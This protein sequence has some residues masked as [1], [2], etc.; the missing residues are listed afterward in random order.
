MSNIVKG[1]GV[2]ICLFILAVFLGTPVFGASTKTAYTRDSVNFISKHRVDENIE[3]GIAKPG[4]YREVQVPLNTVVVGAFLENTSKQTESAYSSLNTS[5]QTRTEPAQPSE[6][7]QNASASTSSIGDRSNFVILFILIAVTGL[8]LFKKRR[9]NIFTQYNKKASDS[10]T[11]LNSE[12][13][14]TK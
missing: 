7:T 12:T 3:V 5:K 1:L 8:Y 4:D 10:G 6:A 2:I 14:E 11:N 9:Q 13:D